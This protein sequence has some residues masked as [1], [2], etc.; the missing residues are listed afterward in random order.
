MD[1][2]IF[3]KN[4]INIISCLYKDKDKVYN[5]KY[6]ESGCNISG[7]YNLE[8]CD[9]DN[10]NKVIKYNCKH[11]HNV[12]LV[13]LI[14]YIINMRILKNKKND[15]NIIKLHMDSYFK[16]CI[17]CEFLNELKSKN[18]F[19]NKNLKKYIVLPE[20]TKNLSILDFY[21]NLNPIKKKNINTNTPQLIRDSPNEDA[22][23][24]II[25]ING[26][27]ELEN[28]YGSPIWNLS[29][30]YINIDILN[31]FK[32]KI[33]GIKINDNLGIFCDE[34]N[35]LFIDEINEEIFEI[36][37]SEKKSFIKY[38][39]NDFVEVNYYTLKKHDVSELLNIGD[40]KIN[41]T[42]NKFLIIKMNKNDIII[43]FFDNCK[44]ININKLF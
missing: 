23:L 37:I 36:E 16:K 1:N 31:Q 9:L 24:Y 8:R 4:I 27:Y 13:S 7:R 44:K 40:L 2:I 35:E 17:V 30:K 10:S 19:I 42:N 21:Y 15:I 39:L 41:Y 12:F 29:Y 38:V 22:K 33:N 25:N 28:I 11:K 14:M 26:I 18:V 43:N 20:I 3:W 5:I 32:K 6:L 34:N